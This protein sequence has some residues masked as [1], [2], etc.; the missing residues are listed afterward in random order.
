[1]IYETNLRTSYAAGRSAQLKAA[2]FPYL[3]YKHNDNVM[4]PRPHH[5]ALDDKI[6]R[7]DDPFLQHAAPPNGF[8]CK[9]WLEGVSERE[10]RRLGKTGPDAPPADWTA[11]EGWDYASGASVGDDINRLIAAK[12]GK[13]PNQI[14]KDFMQAAVNV[15]EAP[16]LPRYPTAVGRAMQQP[17]PQEAAILD[18]MPID[19]YTVAQV[20][21]RP[22]HGW[23]KQQR[24]LT[25]VK[26]RKAIRSLQKQIALHEAW[27]ATPYEKFPADN[28]DPDEVKYHQEYKWPADIARHRQ[29]IEILEG[30]IRERNDKT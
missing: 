29:L 30:V 13:W 22:H 20:P 15:P 1:M 12:T 6:F 25:T 3:R 26:L 9:C 23:L 5:L 18:D 11:D 14:G 21:G 17:I 16:A 24:R 4:V 28:A 7:A 8:G 19:A 10:M 2:G 27:I